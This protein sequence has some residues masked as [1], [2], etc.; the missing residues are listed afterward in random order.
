MTNVDVYVTFYLILGVLLT[1]Q[2]NDR[3]FHPRNKHY[4]LQKQ[5]Y[6][7]LWTSGTRELYPLLETY[8]QFY[9]VQEHDQ[10]Y[11]LILWV[12]MNNIG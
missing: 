6:I 5:I 9:M 10:H 2:V 12:I 11:G 1:L 3:Q 7:L 8:D 4:S